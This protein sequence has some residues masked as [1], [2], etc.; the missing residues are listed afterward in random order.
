MKPITLVAMGLS[1]GPKIGE[2]WAISLVSFVMT[3]TWAPQIHIWTQE[4]AGPFLL[5]LGHAISGL[6]K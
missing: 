4:G 3:R 2:F 5:Y 1:E 6:G